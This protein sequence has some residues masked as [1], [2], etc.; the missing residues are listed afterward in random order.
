MYVLARREGESLVMMHEGVRIRLR[1]LTV[2]GKIARFGIDAPDDIVI[3]REELLE[4]GDE[5]EREAN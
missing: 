5:R 4:T 2:T 3:R 1:V